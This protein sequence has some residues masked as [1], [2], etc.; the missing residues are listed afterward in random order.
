[1]SPTP[2]SDDS[3]DALSTPAL[4]SAAASGSERHSVPFALVHATLGAVAAGE[5]EEAFERLIPEL[6]DWGVKAGALYISEGELHRVA[7]TPIRAESARRLTLYDGYDI[8]GELHLEVDGREQ[9]ELLELLQ[10]VFGLGLGRR[11]RTG[12]LDLI[13]AAVAVNSAESLDEALDALAEACRRISN[14]PNTLITIWEPALAGGIVRAAAGDALA[15]VGER[16]GPGDHV[17]YK[18]A[19]SGAVALGPTDEEK[20]IGPRVERLF[21]RYDH[22]VAVPLMVEG[23]PPIT[24]EVAWPTEPTPLVVERTVTTV[25]KLGALTSV[26]F[27]AAEERAHAEHDALLRGVIET[28]PDGIVVRRGERE[29][30][31]DAGRKILG[32]PADVNTFDRRALKV[33]DLDG[34]PV[35]PVKNPTELANHPHQPGRRRFIVEVGGDDRVVEVSTAPMPEGYVALFRDVTDEHAEFALTQD[36]LE[37]LFESLPLAAAVLDTQTGEV[38]RVNASFLKLVDF[39]AD[40]LVGAQPPYEWCEFFST[41]DDVRNGPADSVYRRSDGTAVH[42]ELLRVTVPGPHGTSG[43]T[44]LLARD[45]TERREFDRRLIQSGK[46]AAIGELASGVAHEIN[47]PLFAIL[48]LVEFLL[49]DIEEGT[50][51]HERLLLIQQTGLEIKEIVKALLDFAR[52]RTDD[53]QPM[54]VRDVVRETVALVHRTSAVRDVEIT[55]DY[56][57]EPVPAIGSAN[58]VKQVILNLITNALQAMKATGGSITV[59]VE[60][61]DTEIV[62]TVADTGP[63][64]DPQILNRIFE[65]FFTTKRDVGGTGLGLAVSHGIAEMHGGT[66]QAESAFGEGTTFTLTLP[67]AGEASG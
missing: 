57:G 35:E 10:D 14:A 50:K 15:T 43:R 16:L 22:V 37:R 62:T 54:L 38:V 26:A 32:L 20:G 67:A 34:T 28:V 9:V 58:Q 39:T 1:M 65:P 21:S 41:V 25:Q 18:A 5:L 61:T 63:G 51:S 31:N 2:D 59:T 12:Q 56:R 6:R 19:S 24:F 42:V 55:E 7:G 11:V 47:N 27:R 60:T 66:L 30:L 52:E 64:I 33:R 53:H 4:K 23:A 8:V 44:V 45:M 13:G 3:L 48:G 40:A 36:F 29:M 46:L 49:R 17:A